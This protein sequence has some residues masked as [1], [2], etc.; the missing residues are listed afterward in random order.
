MPPTRPRTIL[1]LLAALAAS[2]CDSS[3]RDVADALAR[4]E[5][6]RGEVRAVVAGLLAAGPAALA[7]DDGHVYTVDVGQL[8]TWTA[9]AG[10]R[11]W[12]AQLRD[13]VVRELVI[14]EPEQDFTRG[15][16]AWRFLPGTPRSARDASGTTEA[17]RIAEALWEG[18]ERFGRLDDRELAL[19]ILHG[20][21]RHAYVDQGVWLIR[22]YF[23][24]GQR[25][26]APNSY[27]VDYDPDLCRRV[28]DATGDPV[29]GEVAA[30]A[31][32]LVR[33][34][35]SPAGLLHAIV[36]PEVLTL[37]GVPGA[38]FSPNDIEQLSNV[39]AVAERSARTSPDV[40]RGV[41]AF[42]LRAL[43][44]GRLNFNASTGE[45]IG[46]AS[47]RAE[48]HAPLTR[49]AAN[50]ADRSATFVALS[51]LLASSGTLPGDGTRL[52]VAGET[53]LALEHAIALLRAG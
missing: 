51:A 29:L 18:A 27:L 13:L 9:L 19:R 49:L 43:P 38:I 23:N 39:L 45:P 8:M 40:A 26:F 4:A 5:S 32:E 6:R 44:T 42:A 36:Q 1:S 17:L 3:P 14:D 20:Y 33:A 30:R 25:S 10:E 15:F 48:T 37:S 12:Y 50:L 24:L 7:R 22:N 16:V 31:T 46:L 41:L 47:A 52:Y 11:D 35:R 21:A 53:L 28:A 34:A 2:A